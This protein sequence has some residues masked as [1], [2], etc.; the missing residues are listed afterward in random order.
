MVGGEG[1]REGRHGIGQGRSLGHGMLRS[2]RG[3]NQWGRGGAGPHRL[4]AIVHHSLS[5]FSM[6]LDYFNG[7]GFFECLTKIYIITRPLHFSENKLNDK[8]VV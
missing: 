1:L 7:L 8:C 5:L 6:F 2:C 4:I 3:L